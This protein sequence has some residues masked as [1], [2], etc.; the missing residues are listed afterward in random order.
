MNRRVCAS[1]FTCSLFCALIVVS[2]SAQSTVA[3]TPSSRPTVLGEPQTVDQSGS[4]ETLQLPASES[5]IQV[6]RTSDERDGLI[7]LDVASRDETGK[8]Y[9]DLTGTNLTLLQ[10]GAA[11]KILSFHPSSSASEDD[12]ISEVCLVLGACPRIANRCT[13]TVA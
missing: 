5:S 12:R 11:T 7:H 13:V 1:F 10:D 6:T 3:A 9:R 2:G 4:S 8:A